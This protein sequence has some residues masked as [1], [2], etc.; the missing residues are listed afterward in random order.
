M[1]FLLS[2]SA[3][4][5]RELSSSKMPEWT[6]IR[7]TFLLGAG[8]GQPLCVNAFSD[9]GDG[10][11]Y[12]VRKYGYTSF[13]GAGFGGDENCGSVVLDPFGGG[14]GCYYVH[15]TKCGGGYG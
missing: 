9:V 11:G 4:A 2:G 12:S 10:L 15:G 3:D 7:T 1:I 13:T 6:L 5:L 14:V 8:L